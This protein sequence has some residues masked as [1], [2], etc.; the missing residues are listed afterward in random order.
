MLIV[1]LEICGCAFFSIGFPCVAQRVCAI[2]IFPSIL[3]F[4]VVKFF[5]S[6]STLPTDLARL[7]ALFFVNTESPEES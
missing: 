6:L 5:S 1:L 2:P 3:F 4:L 7:K